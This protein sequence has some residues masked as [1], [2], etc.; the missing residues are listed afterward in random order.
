M[1]KGLQKTSSPKI[2]HTSSYV[3][4]TVWRKSHQTFTRL[5]EKMDIFKNL[6]LSLKEWT[7]SDQSV[8]TIFFT[9]YWHSIAGEDWWLLLRIEKKPYLVRKIKFLKFA[10]LI[11]FFKFPFLAPG[12]KTRLVVNNATPPDN[13]IY[14]S[15]H[16]LNSINK[17]LGDL[18][19][20]CATL[21]NSIRKKSW[22]KNEFF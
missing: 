22:N 18:V 17:I 12:N 4:K 20:Q 6:L 11:P 3:L 7:F 10:I 19:Q 5:K 14:D 13:L 15:I 2:F 1:Q 16:Y 21:W 9:L 8:L